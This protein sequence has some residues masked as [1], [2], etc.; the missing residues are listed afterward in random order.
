MVGLWTAPHAEDPQEL[1]EATGADM[2]ATSLWQAV[3]EI[4][5]G[6][7][8]GETTEAVLGSATPRIIW[9]SLTRPSA[10][11]NPE[12]MGRPGVALAQLGS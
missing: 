6:D 3:R 10:V 2:L 1:L 5:E 8:P 7:E 4:E 11:D 9:A 12:R